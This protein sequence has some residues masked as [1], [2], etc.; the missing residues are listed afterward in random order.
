MPFLA[1]FEI[2]AGDVEQAK[3]NPLI[4][5]NKIVILK[6]FFIHETP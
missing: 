2:A 5:T 4:A 3:V 6:I 1:A